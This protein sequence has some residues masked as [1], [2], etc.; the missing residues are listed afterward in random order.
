METADWSHLPKKSLM[1]NF[2]FWL[3]I[4]KKMEVM[5]LTKQNSYNS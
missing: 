4:D 5:I 2:I 3:V 1:E